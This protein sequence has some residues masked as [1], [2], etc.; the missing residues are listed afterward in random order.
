MHQHGLEPVIS[1]MRKRD[2]R[3]AS[4][5][6]SVKERSMPE[7]ARIIGQSPASA[8]RMHIAPNE[9][10]AEIL[11]KGLDVRRIE[12]CTRAKVVMHVDSDHAAGR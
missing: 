12:V 6:R 11:R 10:H 7:L 9:G 5:A 3:D 2:V 4:L 1:V 8:L